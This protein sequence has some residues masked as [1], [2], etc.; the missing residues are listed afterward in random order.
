MNKSVSEIFK[1]ISEEKDINKRKQMLASQSNNQA[2]IGMLQITYDD[3]LQFHLPEGVPPYKP[4]EY[5]DQQG[6]LYQNLRKIG[7]L[8]DPNNK[9]PKLKKEMLF[10]SMLESLDPKDAELLVSIKDKNMPYEGITRDLVKEVFP[11][12]VKENPNVIPLDKNGKKLQGA[13]LKSKL[14]KKK[15]GV[16]VTAN[17]QE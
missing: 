4:C 1:S 10:I 13:A 5:L 15:E 12:L 16:K 6:M 2:V 14:K 17:E 8:L 11:N 7:I 3:N 9:L